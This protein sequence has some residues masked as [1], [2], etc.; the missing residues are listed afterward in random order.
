MTRTPA[1]SRKSDRHSK[2]KK[3]NSQTQKFLYVER[4]LCAVHRDLHRIPPPMLQHQPTLCPHMVTLSN[5]A[6]DARFIGRL[7]ASISMPIRHPT[8]LFCDSDSALTWASKHAKCSASRHISTRHFCVQPTSNR[9][10]LSLPDITGLNF[11]A[12]VTGRAHL[13]LVDITAV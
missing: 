1:D 10:L 11:S 4:C 5:S 8:P 9:A 6:R 2:Q 3:G 13:H 7:H 12:V